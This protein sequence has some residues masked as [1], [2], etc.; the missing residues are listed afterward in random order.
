MDFQEFTFVITLI[1]LNLIFGIGIAVFFVKRHY[2]KEIIQA[3]KIIRYI[4][5]LC[6]IYLLE[7][8]AFSAGMGT[9]VFSIGLAFI[10]GVFLGLWLRKHAISQNLTPISLLLALYTSFPSIS[11]SILLL[12]AWKLAGNSI[13]SVEQGAQFGIP[14]FVPWPL[15]TILGFC[16]AL[17]IGTVIMKAL[18]I[19]VEV[20]LIIHRKNKFKTGHS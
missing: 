17:I 16:L 14:P 8:I 9:Q 1:V 11:F 20:H 18:I 2:F 10:W 15:N 19:S 6:V 5:L 12:L 7:C 3:D 4:A 13:L